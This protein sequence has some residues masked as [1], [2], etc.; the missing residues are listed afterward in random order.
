MELFNVHEI[1]E[2]AIKIE[3]ESFAF[4]TKASEIVNDKDVK[5]L[6]TLLASEEVD[7]QNRLRALINE[8]KINADSLNKK[9]EIDTTLMKRI[10][11]TPEI[12]TKS[13]AMD[14]LEIALEREQNTEQTY[15]ML[16][17]LS[18]IDDDIIEIFDELQ[19][20]EKGHVNKIQFRINHIGA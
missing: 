6:V 19:L 1:I 4:Y 3:Q 13:T 14:V 9:Y 18:N 7:H 11:N 8:E 15:A 20:Q 2:Y 16:I 17:T 5:D 12:T 10:I